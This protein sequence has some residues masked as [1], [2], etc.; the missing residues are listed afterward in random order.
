MPARMSGSAMAE[1]AAGYREPVQTTD[2]AVPELHGRDCDFCQLSLA[3]RNYHAQL[4]SA[5]VG[6]YALHSVRSPTHPLP[7]C[8]ECGHRKWATITP[9]LKRCEQCGYTASHDLLADWYAQELFAQACYYPNITWVDRASAATHPPRYHMKRAKKPARPTN[10]FHDEPVLYVAVVEVGTEP[11]HVTFKKALPSS[12]KS[13]AIK[14][15]AAMAVNPCPGE[16]GQPVVL[17]AYVVEMR[18][19]VDGARVAELFIP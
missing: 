14:N 6:S 7:A 15:L 5:L 11:D 8:R 9:H 12:V 4:R 17:A 19:V 13:D 16:P 10:P 1:L 3:W 2:S 18:R